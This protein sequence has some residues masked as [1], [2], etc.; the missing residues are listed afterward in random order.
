MRTCL[1][2]FTSQRHVLRSWSP[3]LS[4]HVPLEGRHACSRIPPFTSHLLSYAYL[5]GAFVFF[6]TVEMTN[7]AVDVVHHFKY[8]GRWLDAFLVKVRA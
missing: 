4:H 2:L 8:E 3:D 7:K 6:P 5:G 1:T